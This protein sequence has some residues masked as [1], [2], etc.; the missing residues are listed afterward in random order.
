MG[1]TFFLILIFFLTRTIGKILSIFKCVPLTKYYYYL[2]TIT[3]DKILLLF[4][5]KACKSLFV[6][7]Y[8]NHYLFPVQSVFYFPFF[9][10]QFVPFFS[11]L[12]FLFVQLVARTFDARKEKWPRLTERRTPLGIMKPP[13]EPLDAILPSRYDI[14][15]L[16]CTNQPP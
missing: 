10:V 15:G 8:Q 9:L 4:K 7:M 11:F 1:L 2:N 12:F 5:A 16:R 6:W 3:I 14:D 13:L